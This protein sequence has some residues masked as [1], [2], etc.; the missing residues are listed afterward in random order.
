MPEEDSERCAGRILGAYFRAELRRTNRAVSEQCSA[1]TFLGIQRW[2]EESLYDAA[3]EA[4][5]SDEMMLSCS[6]H[7][8]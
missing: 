8:A 2:K 3:I 5:R 4:R 6:S 7:G 1:M